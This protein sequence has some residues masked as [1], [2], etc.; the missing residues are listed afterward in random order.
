MSYPRETARLR[1]LVA[2][3]AQI[4]WEVPHAREQAKARGVSVLIAERVIRRGSVVILGIEPNGTE[5][6]TVAGRDSDGRPVNVV[7]VP[8]APDI[9]RVI[10]VIRTDQ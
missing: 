9:L 4:S 5:R 2:S 3:G 7:V 6:W 10:T 8:V 1:A